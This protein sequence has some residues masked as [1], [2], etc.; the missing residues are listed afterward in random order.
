[1]AILEVLS[2]MGSGTSIFSGID[3]ALRRFMNRTAE[4]LFKVCFVDAVRQSAQNLAHLTET[5]DSET[6]SV[7]ENTLDDVINSLDDIDI[8]AL[9][10]TR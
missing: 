3:V 1:M 8:S 6:V 4:D 5:R 7:D 9:H 2:L 10:V